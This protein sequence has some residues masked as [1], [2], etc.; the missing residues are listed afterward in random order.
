L[1]EVKSAVSDIAEA[2]KR[3][4]D[5]ITRI[6]LLLS[7]GVAEPSALSVNEVIRDVLG[8]T[9]ETM[10]TKRITLD[11]RLAHDAPRVLADRVQLQ[12]VLVN[13][14]TNAADAMADISDRPRTVTISSRCDDKHQLEV[15]VADSGTG[16]DPRYRDRIFDPFF[17]T[18]SDGM[19]MGLA[20]CRGIVEAWGG[21]LW[22]TSNEDFG[23]T[24]RFALPS[25]ATE[26]V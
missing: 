11:T 20:I 25:A 6:R 3:A 13:L 22:A 7:K 8:L 5:V 23:T 17:T 19:G 12:Q 21:R 24:F 26:G 2:G 4:S 9:R 15:A 10:R 18:K 14:V 16:L 1:G